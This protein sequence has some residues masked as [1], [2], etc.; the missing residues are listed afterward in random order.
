[1]II[2]KRIVSWSEP[3]DGAARSD[4]RQLCVPVGDCRRSAEFY[5]RVFGLRPR[6]A[7]SGNAAPAELFVTD[8]VVRVCLR[9]AHCVSLPAW[10]RTTRWGFVVADLDATRA[11]V[12]EL[13]VQVVRDSG[14]LD[15]IYRRS[16][17]DSLYVRDPDGNEIELVEP[18]GERHPVA[19]RVHTHG[20]AAW[21]FAPR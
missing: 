17:A 8:G 15:H 20:N 6:P 4:I 16:G 19:A 12:W 1:V 7:L 11:Q 3:D 18:H 14:E 13:G 9:R 10:L 2:V 21:F 5:R